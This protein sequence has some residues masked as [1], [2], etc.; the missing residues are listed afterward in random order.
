MFDLSALVYGDAYGY[1]KKKNVEK[2]ISLLKSF[3][4]KMVRNKVYKHFTD[5]EKISFEEHNKRKAQIFNTLFDIGKMLSSQI[6]GNSNSIN[7]SRFLDYF[8]GI[9]DQEI[10]EN[11]K[12]LL[13][14]KKAILV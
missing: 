7:V 8:E 11:S 3:N 6:K 9:S 1:I 14:L 4:K 2:L 12:N 10:L 13:F 5:E